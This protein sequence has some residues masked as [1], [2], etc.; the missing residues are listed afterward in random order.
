MADI[1]IPLYKPDK[2][3]DR[4]LEQLFLQTVRPER[5]ILMNTVTEDF[6]TK[7]L[8][9]RVQRIANR[10]DR[11]GVDAVAVELHSVKKEEFNHGGTRRL[12]AELVQS[13]IFVCM[14]QDAIPA[15][16]FLLE[17]LLKPFSNSFISAAYAR[18]LASE[19]A[20]FT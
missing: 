20:N 8:E 1:I 17:K 13:D 4:L 3:F 6:T 12:A 11:K 10:C 5:I 18:Q 16:V 19:N 9:R 7:D 14:T 2:K 15:D